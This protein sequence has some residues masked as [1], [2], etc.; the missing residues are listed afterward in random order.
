MRKPKPKPPDDTLEVRRK[1]REAGRTPVPD[2]DADRIW[3][4][5]TGEDTDPEAS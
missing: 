3:R 5:A 4:K 2:P 1:L